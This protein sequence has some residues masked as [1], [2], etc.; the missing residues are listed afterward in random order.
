VL[1]E[2]QEAVIARFH[3]VLQELL[4]IAMPLFAYQQ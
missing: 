4:S 1:N 3:D 2:V